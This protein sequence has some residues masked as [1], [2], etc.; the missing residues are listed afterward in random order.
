M[1]VCL[2]TQCVCAAVTVLHRFE[3]LLKP[4]LAVALQHCMPSDKNAPPSR[5]S[6]YVRAIQ[7]ATL[8]Y[9]HQACTWGS[10]PRRDAVTPNKPGII[11]LW[12]HWCLTALATAADAFSDT[13]GNNSFF[14]RRVADDGMHAIHRIHLFGRG[15]GVLVEARPQSLHQMA[16]FNIIRLC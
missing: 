16:F 3:V 4:P 14:R 10:L 5:R 12:L 13:F 9:H 11:R 7:C 2:F 6:L 8:S 1:R 15:G